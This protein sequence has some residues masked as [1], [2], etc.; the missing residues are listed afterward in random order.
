MSQSTDPETLIIN[1]K[2]K[3]DG[4]GWNIALFEDTSKV[5]NCLCK[6]CS[7]VCCD[8]VELGCDHQ[9]DDDIFLYCK[10][11]L[12]LLVKDNDNQCMISAHQNPPI[13]AVR[14]N[15]RQ[16]LK[17]IVACPYSLA[18][19]IRNNFKKKKNEN[20]EII[21]TFGNDEKEGSQKMAKGLIYKNSY[22]FIKCV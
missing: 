4:G 11:C 5:S 16:I 9:D 14:S 19:K 8:A 22:I 12:I 6:H 15:R 2:L 1:E 17:A 3:I 13:D 20:A 10:V 18:F 7:G 21:D